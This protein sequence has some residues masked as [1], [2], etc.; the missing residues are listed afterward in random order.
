MASIMQLLGFPP[1]EKRDS[2]HF[3]FAK[4]MAYER[5][6][7]V[8]TAMLF[9]GLLFQVMVLNPLPGIPFLIIAVGLML[10]KGYDSR[11]RL[12][13]YQP[14]TNWTDVDM[15]RIEQIE[16]LRKRNQ[17]WDKDSIDIS[18]LRGCMMFLVMGIA[19][20][21]LTV[22]TL[23][24]TKNIVVA[25]IIPVDAIFLFVP[26]WFTG[27]RFI[28]SQPNLA[29]KIR[30]LKLVEGYFQ[31]LKEENEQFVPALMLT[32]DEKGNAVPIDAR[33][34]IR[35]GQT[36]AGLYGLQAQININ[37]VQGNSYPYFYCVIAAKPGFGL[38]RFIG[39]ET[40]I[41]KVIIEYQEDAN[42]E[43]LVIRQFTT[44]TS[45]YHTNDKI[46]WEILWIA[47][48]LARKLIVEA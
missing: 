13:K 45:G 9:L 15:E 12:K 8:A 2:V 24:F 33:F 17:E 34:T 27:M 37:L 39:E 26:M 6:I 30:V 35:F 31:K 41:K 7:I 48:Q 42:A 43:V 25:L 47:V 19:V 36:P 29:V 10:V 20:T 14:D 4:S 32:K 46:C 38:K 18:N 44:K 28:L 22:L 3:Y 1:P 21:A 40:Q 11:A 23:V 5:R 16:D